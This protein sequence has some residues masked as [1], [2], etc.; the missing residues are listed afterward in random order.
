MTCDRCWRVVCSYCW[1]GVGEEAESG[2][3]QF[4]TGSG[5]QETE[6][7]RRRAQGL[8]TMYVLIETTNYNYKANIKSKK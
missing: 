8:W 2:T 7:Y 4:W 5:A 1:G 6:N 3:A